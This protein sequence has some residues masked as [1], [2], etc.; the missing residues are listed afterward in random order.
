MAE[1]AGEQ[2]A[3]KVIGEIDSRIRRMIADAA[4]G[5]YDEN[6]I[7]ESVLAEL[8]LINDGR[9]SKDFIT[10]L[11]ME[12][13]TSNDIA[14][15]YS[16]SNALF[17]DDDISLLL[18]NENDGEGEEEQGSFPALVV[19]C[20]SAMSIPYQP[21]VITTFLSFLR[22]LLLLSQSPHHHHRSICH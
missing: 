14:L 5:R 15:A 4:E 8:Q 12:L 13:C 10:A 6:D 19:M 9:S 7:K 3:T 18:D 16:S 11:F 22:L 20:F 2:V 17:E 21:T 1:F